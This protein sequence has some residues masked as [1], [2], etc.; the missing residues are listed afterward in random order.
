MTPAA[1]FRLS[2]GQRFGYS[3]GNLPAEL[4]WNIILGWGMYFLSPPADK[5]GV[6]LYLPATLAGM[7]I[8]LGRVLN[9]ISDPLVG[10]LSDKTKTRWGRRM[11]YIMFATPLFLLCF[12]FFWFAPVPAPTWTQ[13]YEFSLF[14]RTLQITNNYLPTAVWLFLFAGGF[15]FLY[16][17][18]I[19][20]YLSLLPEITPD[21]DE[22]LNISMWQAYVGVVATILALGLVGYLIT[23]LPQGITLAGF[24]L[25]DMYKVIALA[26]VL[27]SALCLY[28]T[29]F[30][31]KETAYSEKK[32]VPYSIL[33]AWWE[34]LKNRAFLP[35]VV[36]VALLRLA[37]DI[38]IGSIPFL[39]SF[40]LAQT[41]LLE[42]SE[43]IAGGVQLTIMIVAAAMFPLTNFLS[44]KYTKRT[45]FLVCLL[46]FGLCLPAWATLH[47]WVGIPPVYRPF[48]LFLFAAPP[49]SAMLVL[50][51]P[52]L[53]DIIDF[54][55]TLTGFRR[56][57]VYNGVE[58]LWTKS[59]S[60]LSP[61][62]LG[63]LFDLL[64]NT[65]DR[66]LGIIAV[67]PVAGVIMLLSVTAFWHYPIKK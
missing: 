46:W 8:G 50:P 41:N 7:V 3:L 58:G 57:S 26:S 2:F 15:Y 54:D 25:P 10:Y 38:V 42:K 33:R 29:V 45:V 51:R 39:M 14:G 49:V 55:E 27:L 43:L 36:S 22:R 9:G 32:E 12:L 61:L 56:E 65:H 4:L 66:P 60:A 52:I 37:A 47:W 64:G 6:T 48:L 16:A 11:P 53:A 18:V 24:H 44:Q 67:G 21:N 31:L 20:P 1:S 34:T 28:P 30:I 23:E 40:L 62:I 19:N 17:I 5:T 59:F 63:L 13:Q 35:W